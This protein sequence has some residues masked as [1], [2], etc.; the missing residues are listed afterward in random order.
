MSSVC[1]LEKN[2]FTSTQKAMSWITSVARG[3]Q[4]VCNE[5]RVLEITDERNTSM[6]IIKA[7]N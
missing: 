3:Q 6:D 7:D 5:Q 2:T 4:L 1:F